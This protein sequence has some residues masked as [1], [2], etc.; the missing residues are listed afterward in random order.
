[1]GQ[2]TRRPFLRRQGRRRGE[3]RGEAHYPKQPKRSPSHGPILLGRRAGRLGTTEQ[4]Q[5]LLQRFQVLDQLGFLL[6]V[7]PEPEVPVVV[8]DHGSQV[9]EA[10]VVIEAAL[11]V[12]P[13]AGERRGAVLVRR[14]AV[15]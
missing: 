11:L 15:R 5:E 3:R 13:Q 6:R 4:I 9:R 12:R 1:E 7:Q 14:R 10:A 8:V 2:V